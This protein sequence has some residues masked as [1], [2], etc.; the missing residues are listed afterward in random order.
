MYSKTPFAFTQDS[1]ILG[2]SQTKDLLMS[3][4]SL[5][6]RSSSLQHLQ[7]RQTMARTETN[8][9]ARVIASVEK[10]MRSQIPSSQHPHEFLVDKLRQ[11][12]GIHVKVCQFQDLE[13]FFAHPTEED[14]DAYTLD[15][16]DAVRTSNVP[17]LRQYHKERRTLK[18]SNRFGE[19]LLHLAAR[20]ELVD[21]VQ[22][23]LYEAKLSPAICDDY[24][25]TPLHDACWSTVP[26]FALVD[27]IINVCPDLLYI[28]D[29]RGHTPL[30]YA[31]QNHWP[32]W[33]QHL[34]GRLDTLAPKSHFLRVTEPS[35]GIASSPS[36]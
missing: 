7:T 31:R 34:E 12:R 26:N 10:D 36:S 33:I 4:K 6:R 18:C 2:L 3:A 8:H 9:N 32:A 17:L 23:L 21:V 13:N 22:F 15:M 11:H 1:H 16:I 35:V 27:L 30:F 25:R 20:K 29:R 5:K 14:I 19:S 28:K 24:G